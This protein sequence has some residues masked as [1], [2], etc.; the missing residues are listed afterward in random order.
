[1]SLPLFWKLLKR[2]S[3]SL[4]YVWK[5]ICPENSTFQGNIP[6]YIPNSLKTSDFWDNKNQHHEFILGT[7]EEYNFQEMECV[8]AIFSWTTQG[9]GDFWILVI[10][11]VPHDKALKPNSASSRHW[12]SFLLSSLCK[13]C[14]WGMGVDFLTEQFSWTVMDPENRCVQK[15]RS[16]YT[17]GTY[18]VSG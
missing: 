11:L 17:I 10:R 1:M 8:S 16:V 15:N 7:L 6:S 3:H 18:H 2:D 12:D 9:F 5:N 4:H 14:L 13:R